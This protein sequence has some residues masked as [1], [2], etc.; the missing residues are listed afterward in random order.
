MI[1]PAP[2]AII[3]TKSATEATIQESLVSIEEGDCSMNESRRSKSLQIAL[4][5]T[6]AVASGQPRVS[7]LVAE[8]HA[9]SAAMQR[10]KRKCIGDL[11]IARSEATKQS[12]LR[13]VAKWIAS[14]SLSSGRASRGPVGSQ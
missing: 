3:M 11:V 1:Q 7:F 10:V 12:M 8:H 9:S 6:I 5:L 4:E 13:Q 14:R 2:N